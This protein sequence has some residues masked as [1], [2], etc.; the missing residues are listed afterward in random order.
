MS[1]NQQK[2]GWV[3][4]MPNEGELPGEINGNGGGLPQDQKLG[5]VRARIYDDLEE[6][7]R[8]IEED[9]QRRIAAGDTAP[10]LGKRETWLTGE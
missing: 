3:E 4:I 2:R 9:D 10:W 5:Q 1:R 6:R 7:K 8:L